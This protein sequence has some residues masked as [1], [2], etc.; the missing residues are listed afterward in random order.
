M[1]YV[2]DKTGVYTFQQRLRDRNVTLFDNITK[3]RNSAYIVQSKWNASLTQYKIDLLRELLD[4]RLMRGKELKK[5]QRLIFIYLR[6]LLDVTLWILSLQKMGIL[7]KKGVSNAIE[8]Q[9]Y[10]ISTVAGGVDLGLTVY[11]V[12]Y[13]LSKIKSPIQDV[14]QKVSHALQIGDNL[15]LKFA[16]VVKEGEKLKSLHIVSQGLVVEHLGVGSVLQNIQL[17]MTEKKELS[18]G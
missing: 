9:N 18:K 5:K 1:L 13:K 15:L 7:R 10:F 17:I 8:S 2:S 6:L 14:I 4:S 12:Q 11:L 3:H 16:L